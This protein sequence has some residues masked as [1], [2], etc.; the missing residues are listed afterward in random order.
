MKYKILYYLLFSALLIALIASV[1]TVSHPKMFHV[2]TLGYIILLS[3]IIMLII[4]R[5]P[6]SKNTKLHL[7]LPPKLREPKFM[8]SGIYVHE[9]YRYR[10]HELVPGDTFWDADYGEMVWTGKEWLS[11]DKVPSN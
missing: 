9:Q 5:K 4:L 1:I 10:E 11:T 7:M 6:S 2:H 3:T 8:G